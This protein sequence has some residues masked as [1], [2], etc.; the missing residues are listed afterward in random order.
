[1]RDMSNL[2]VFMTIQNLQMSRF[3]STSVLV[4]SHEYHD[5]IE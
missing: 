2:F 3:S 1:M 5:S 4:W